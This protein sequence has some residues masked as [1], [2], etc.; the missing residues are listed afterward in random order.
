MPLRSWT[1]FKDETE[2]TISSSGSEKILK[3]TKRKRES[4]KVGSSVDL[5]NKDMTGSE[6]T[7]EHVPDGEG[8]WMKFFT[9]VNE[10]PF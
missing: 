1:C 10:T 3:V 2:A 6:M 9:R 7:E 8:L 5:L 4:V